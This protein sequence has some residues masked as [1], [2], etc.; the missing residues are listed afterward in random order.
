MMDSFASAFGSVLGPYLGSFPFTVL[1]FMGV[2][3][4]VSKL[5]LTKKQLLGVLAL[6][7]LP[8]FGVWTSIASKEAVS[9][10]FM[11]IILAAYID[12]YERRALQ[13]K[14]L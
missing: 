5:Q 8:S 12:I 14:F 11:G 10:F 1:A 6:L 4:P 7:S 3:Y 13:N 9:V 2:Y